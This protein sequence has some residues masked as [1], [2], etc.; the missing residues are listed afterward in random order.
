MKANG[1]KRFI[2]FG[3]A[4][5]KD[6]NA[7]ANADDASVMV[8]DGLIKYIEN[9]DEM[10]FILGHEIDH[11]TLKHDKPRYVPS[12]QRKRLGMGKLL[13]VF[14][15]TGGI[16]AGIYLIGKGLQRVFTGRQESYSQKL[17]LAADLQGIKYMTN[18]GYDPEGGI[19]VMYK[20]GSDRSSKIWASHPNGSTRVA[21][22]NQWLEAYQASHSNTP[23]VIDIDIPIV[24]TATPAEPSVTEAAP[25]EALVTTPIDGDTI[26]Q[27]GQPTQ[28]E[29][30]VS[31]KVVLTEAEGVAA[32]TE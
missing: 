22:L 12:G 20:I 3:I 5:E 23:Q 27:V 4:H 32:E 21:Q 10:A 29:T 6:V 17:E 2:S 31:A 24:N 16:G 7:F 30:S 25:E 18:A 28:A 26:S 8:Y 11:I 9:D 14:I 1:I 13:V 15:A 19:E